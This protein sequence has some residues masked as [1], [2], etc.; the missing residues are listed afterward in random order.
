M[1]RRFVAFF[2]FAL[3]GAAFGLPDTVMAAAGLRAGSAGGFRGALIASHRPRAVFHA[4]P[5]SRIQPAYASQPIRPFR[6][7]AARAGTIPPS[8]HGYATT[9]PLRPFARLERRHHRIYH[10]GWVFPATSAG[11][12]SAGFIGTAYDPAEM[13]PVYAPLPE[14]VVEPALPPDMRPGTTAAAIRS[15]AES[16]DP[17]NVCR[18]ER[19]TVPSRTG[20][21]EITVVR[22]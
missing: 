11:D 10:S 19:V 17:D 6:P 20:Q 12:G 18:A 16:E 8:P 7:S 15:A 9:S 3:I 22:C 1:S 13:I 14:N 4:V 21:R 5:R 2:A